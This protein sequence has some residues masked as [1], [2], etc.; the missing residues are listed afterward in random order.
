MQSDALMEKT[1]LKVPHPER[2]STGN[3]LIQSLLQYQKQSHVESTNS[4]TSSAWFSVISR[5]RFSRKAGY[6]LTF[7]NYHKNL[8]MKLI[9]ISYRPLEM[10]VP[11]SDWRLPKFVSARKNI[12]IYQIKLCGWSYIYQNMTNCFNLWPGVCSF[13]SQKESVSW[14]DSIQPPPTY[15]YEVDFAWNTA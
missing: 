10:T 6:L 14:Y 1:L 2:E 8:L 13:S 5:C 11:L 12:K 15:I 7:L 9:Y 4:C 3:I